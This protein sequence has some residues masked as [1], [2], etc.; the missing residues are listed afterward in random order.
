MSHHRIVSVFAV[1]L[2]YVTIAASSAVLH[3]ASAQDLG[4]PDNPFGDIGLESVKPKQ[5]EKIFDNGNIYAVKN[6]PTRATVITLHS[7]ARFAKITTYHWNNGRG[8]P[9]G[10]IALSSSSGETFG[11]WQASGQPGQ[12]G[13]PSAYWVVE[14]GI[15]LPAG[16]YT[17]I[18]SNPATWAQNDV[19]GG[20]G[21]VSV[22]GYSE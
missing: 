19:T 11:P 7:P 20:A 8:A 21:M 18:D 16:S 22:E 6:Q 1:S 10:T 12:G 13:A 2:V 9:A 17:V 3:M 15:S 14:P 4:T 5:I